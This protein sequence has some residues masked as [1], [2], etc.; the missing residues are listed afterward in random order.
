MVSTS[1]VKNVVSVLVKNVGKLA[2]SVKNCLK[3]LKI[4]KE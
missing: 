3:Y 4:W 2:K 1:K